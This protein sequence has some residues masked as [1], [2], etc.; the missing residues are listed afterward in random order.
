MWNADEEDESDVKCY[1]IEHGSLSLT[2]KHE[3]KT[4]NNADPLFEPFYLTSFHTSSIPK[5]SCL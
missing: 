5:Q 3:H 1:D 4:Q 2:H